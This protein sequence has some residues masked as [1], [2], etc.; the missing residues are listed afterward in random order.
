MGGLVQKIIFKSGTEKLPISKEVNFFSFK[1]RDIDGNMVDFANLK[2][3]FK[4]FIVVNVACK[5]GLTSVNY[6]ELVRI[7]EKYHKDGLEVLAFPCNQF[8]SQESGGEKEIKQFVKENFKVHFPMFSKIEVNG[9]NA[10]PLFQYLRNN[11]ELYDPKKGEAGV[12]PWNFAKFIVDRNGKVIK[13]AH[14]T[15]KPEELIPIIEK[16]LSYWRDRCRSSKYMKLT[17]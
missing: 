15:V 4:L 14:P 12:V 6:Q 13:F 9:P 17:A 10:D 11:S 1:E 7:Y 3:K 2:G 8:F 16:E 5:W